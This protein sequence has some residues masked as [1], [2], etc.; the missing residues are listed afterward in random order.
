[1][2]L[3][4]GKL[5]WPILFM[6]LLGISRIPGLM[7]WNFS[8]VYGLVFCAGVFLP[9]RFAWWMPLCTVFISDLLLNRCYY[10]V[11]LFTADVL[12]NY[13]AYLA[14][15]W[16]ARRFNRKSSFLSLLCGGMGGAILFYLITNTLSWLINP[17]HNPEYTK[18]LAGWIVALTRGTG[19]YPQTW[20]FFRNTLMSGGLFTGLFA[21][22]MKLLDAMEPED[23]KE[24]EEEPAAEPANEPNHEPEKAEA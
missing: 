8:A 10:H 6:L 18:T 19:G 9:L 1:M 14:I 23:E 12:G 24:S 3:M 20:E 7:P 2:A 22:A 4:K 5:F 21:G 16:L 15:L 11:P 17:Y 13:V